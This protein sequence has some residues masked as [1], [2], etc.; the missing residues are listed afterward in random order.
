MTDLYC[1]K[2]YNL[3][4]TRED[5]CN[6]GGIPCPDPKEVDPSTVVKVSCGPCGRSWGIPVGDVMKG[7]T[8][9]KHSCQLQ[10]C[11]ATIIQP[12]APE[13]VTL[14]KEVP[15]KG[16][17]EGAVL[18]EDGTRV[19]IAAEFLDTGAFHVMSATVD[20]P[21]GETTTRTQPVKPAKK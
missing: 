15:P 20:A 18:L 14:T 21:V 9:G 8:A 6:V 19:G 10:V 1:P 16:V 2:D 12:D 17:L 13:P 4:D 3:G 7:R 11:A 5:Q